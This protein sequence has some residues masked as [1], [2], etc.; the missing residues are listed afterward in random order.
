MHIWIDTNLKTIS[1][2]IESDIFHA[3]TYA[4][5]QGCP[6]FNGEECMEC[7]NFLNNIGAELWAKYRFNIDGKMVF[8]ISDIKGE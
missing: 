8:S 5:S 1:L 4:Q 3:C 6:E 7:I 2:T